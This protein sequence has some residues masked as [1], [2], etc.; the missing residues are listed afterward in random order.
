VGRPFDV[1]YVA[2]P[3]YEDI[4]AK[5][6]GVLDG[7]CGRF[8]TMEGEES[9]IVVAQIDPKEYRELGLKHLRLYDQRKYGRTMFCFYEAAVETAEEPKYLEVE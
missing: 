7:D 2:P 1:I 3:Q 5:V 8:L 6:L 9:G 4:W